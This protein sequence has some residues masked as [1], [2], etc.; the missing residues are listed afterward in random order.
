M[1]QSRRPALGRGLSALI[2]SAEAPPGGTL[3]ISQVHRPPRSPTAFDDARIAELSASIE[4]KWHPAAHPGA[5][6]LPR[7]LRDHRWRAPLPGR[8]AP[9]SSRCPSRHPRGDRLQATSWPW[10]SVQREDL[11]PVEEALAYR[12]LAKSAE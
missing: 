2:P 6:P 8:A 12:H 3:P 9:A 7:A 4:A 11:N 5:A 10:S 1:S